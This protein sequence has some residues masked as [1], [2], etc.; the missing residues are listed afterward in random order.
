MYINGFQIYH[1]VHSV[2]IA[3]ANVQCAL[4]IISEALKPLLQFEC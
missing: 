2:C 3:I 1:N 4:T